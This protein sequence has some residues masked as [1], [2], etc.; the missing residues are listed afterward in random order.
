MLI[1]NGLRKHFAIRGGML[2]RR[3]ATVRAVDDVSF[4]VL[5]AETL[6]IV[7]ES[8]CGKSTLARLL[9]HLIPS[10]SGGLIFDGD[11]V[12]E[13]RGLSLRAATQHADGFP[14]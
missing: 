4:C 11:M 1:A 13:E 7:G 14:G 10:D 9:M 8:G 2:N 3:I 12:G 5:K 6:G